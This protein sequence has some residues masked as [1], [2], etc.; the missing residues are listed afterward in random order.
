MQITR[1]SECSL[2]T[3]LEVWNM[4][5]KGYFVNVTMTLTQFVKRVANDG[6]SPEHSLIAW[7]DGKPIGCIFTGV[8][9]ISGKR[10]AWN[11]GTAVVPEHRGQGVGQRMMQACLDVYRELDVDVAY[12]EA[13]VQ[14]APAIRLYQQSG[15]KI[16]NTVA[17]LVRNGPLSARAFE[18]ETGSWRTVKSG[19]PHE[20]MSLPFYQPFST[21]Q[22]QWQSL[23][24]GESL[25][26]YDNEATPIAYA[27]YKRTPDESGIT[28][29]IVLYQC[30]TIPSLQNKTSALRRLLHDVYVQHELDC[31]RMAVNIPVS[32]REVIGIL[33]G[34]GF[35]ISEQQVSMMRQMKR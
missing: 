35:T 14:N 30:E 32:N 33:E 12:L 17:L 11:G 3:A 29:S 1:M 4:G 24:G 18:G 16:V 13:L 22:T 5:F 15:Y 26:L 20:V 31:M 27:L 6:L 19:L 23:A 34:E 9:D 2:N 7:V 21:W 28:K 8:R 25:I 10:I